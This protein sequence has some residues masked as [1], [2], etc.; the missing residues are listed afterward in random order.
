MAFDLIDEARAGSDFALGELL[1][2]FRPYLSML[3]EEEIPSNLR[4]KGGVSDLVQE[5]YA[6]ACRDWPAFRGT[7]DAEIRTWLARILE[8]Q[9][10]NFAHRYRQTARRCIEREQPL[11]ERLNPQNRAADETPSQQLIRQETAESL[12][13]CLARLSAD[14]QQV[15]RLRHEEQRSFGEIAMQMNRTEVAVRRLWARAMARWQQE[16]GMFDGGI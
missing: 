5:T 12:M 15:I 2:Q 6:L 14:D 16:V 9:A 4:A 3:A 8:H 10:I 7:S 11:D 1:E 13:K